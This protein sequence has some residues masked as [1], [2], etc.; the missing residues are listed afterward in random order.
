MRV[1]EWEFLRIYEHVICAKSDIG[2]EIFVAQIG[3]WGQNVPARYPHVSQQHFSLT[4]FAKME[5]Q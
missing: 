1:C 2:R 3:L 5:G 4:Q